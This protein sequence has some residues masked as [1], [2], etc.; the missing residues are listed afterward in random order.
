MKKNR[1]SKMPRAERETYI[2]N[3]IARIIASVVPKTAG[4]TR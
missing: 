2:A 1:K 3:L 4:A